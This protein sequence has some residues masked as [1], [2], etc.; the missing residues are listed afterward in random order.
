MAEV[1]VPTAVPREQKR[2]LRDQT[3][4]ILVYRVGIYIGGLKPLINDASDG[5]T[6][7]EYQLINYRLMGYQLSYKMY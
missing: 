5:L 6:T 4:R 7:N 1:V 3:L 2:N